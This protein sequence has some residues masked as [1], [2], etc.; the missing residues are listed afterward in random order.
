MLLK[1]AFT[2]MEM[3]AFLTRRGYQV[4]EKEVIAHEIL[5]GSK[6]VEWKKTEWTAIKEDFSG[7][8]HTVFEHELKTKLLNE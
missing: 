8:L 7:R 2:D 1:I 4:I 5:H 6:F 3:I